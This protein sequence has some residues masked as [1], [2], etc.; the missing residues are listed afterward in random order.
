MGDRMGEAVSTVSVKREPQAGTCPQCGAER[1]ESYPA[2]SEG[3]WFMVV[4]CQECL[5]SLS[6]TLWNRLGY[7]V[8]LEDTL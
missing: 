1:L 4:K 2:L 6:R 8:R 3:G 7:V 5:A